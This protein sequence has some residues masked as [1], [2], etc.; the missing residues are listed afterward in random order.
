MRV[1]RGFD[2]RHVG[3]FVLKRADDVEQEVCVVP[4]TREG[5][6][7]SLA[8]G[9]AGGRELVKG[10]AAQ[11]AI[12]SARPARPSAQLLVRFIAAALYARSS[13]RM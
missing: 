5:A 8:P 13:R 6:S 9:S 1:T 4:A 10:V 7:D 12:A 3:F 11:A 2:L